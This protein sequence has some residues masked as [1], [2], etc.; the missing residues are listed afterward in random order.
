[1]VNVPETRKRLLDAGTATRE[2][3]RRLGGRTSLLEVST[4]HRHA[5][6]GRGTRA[7]L[8]IPVSVEGDEAVQLV[9]ELNAWELETPNLPPY[10]G[11]W[12]PGPHGPMFL[13]FVP[14]HL[15]VPG[16]IMNLATW[17]RGRAGAVRRWMGRV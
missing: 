17:A 4:Q 13:T 7:T 12:M 1:M 9:K 10:F 15:C 3:I 16:L 6:F 5:L 8:Q 2:D 14:T 11:A